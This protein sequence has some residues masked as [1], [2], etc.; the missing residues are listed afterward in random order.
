M[1]ARQQCAPALATTP[2]SSGAKRKPDTSFTRVAPAA[3]AASATSRLVVSI[4]IRWPAAASRSTTGTARA[5]SSAAGTGSAPG[6][7]E[8]PPTSRIAAPSATS[9]SPCS[10]A[11]SG[12]RNS[13]PSE[14]ESGVTLTMPMTV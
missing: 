2:A 11:A 9:C 13:P 12:S 8:A 6:R 3:S 10:T 7:V 4:E 1:W 14:N 5:S